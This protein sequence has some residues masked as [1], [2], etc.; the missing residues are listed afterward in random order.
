MGPAHV[1][2]GRVEPLEEANVIKTLRL[3]NLDT[4]L[5]KMLLR[6]DNKKK[7]QEE[8]QTNA[9]LIIF[10][11]EQTLIFLLWRGLPLNLAA[12]T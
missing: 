1:Q 5:D 8:T 10:S 11:L 4:I 6:T 9:Y 2:M 12:T 7:T 3:Q